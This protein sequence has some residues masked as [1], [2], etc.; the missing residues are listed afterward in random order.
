MQ[1]V[2]EGRGEAR[3]MCGAVYHFLVSLQKIKKYALMGKGVVFGNTWM[4]MCFL[5]LKE[6]ELKIST[7]VF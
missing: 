7:V 2:A 1:I 6:K 4:H 3:R 5:N